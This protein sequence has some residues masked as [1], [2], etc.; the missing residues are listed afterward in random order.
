MMRFL[1]ISVLA[2][3]VAP[4]V[5]GQAMTEHAAAAAGGSVGGVAGKRVSDGMSNIF[6]KIDG[7]AKTT[8]KAGEK[9]TAKPTEEPMLKLGTPQVVPRNGSAAA[10]PASLPAPSRRASAAGPR[11]THPAHT[12]AEGQEPE[13]PAPAVAVAA[14]RPVVPEIVPTREVLSGLTAGTKREAVLAKL[15]TPASSITM[16]EDGAALE[17]LRFASKTGNVGTVRLLDGVVS[18]IVIQEN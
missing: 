3:S 10:P 6:G 13:A 1:S 17:I 9:S 12:A 7:Q 4:L 18:E 15:G 16:Y 8:A 5:F 2:L 11:A 14:P